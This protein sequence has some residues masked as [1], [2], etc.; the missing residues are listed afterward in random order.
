MGSGISTEEVIEKAT[1]I[2]KDLRIRIS[3][4]EAAMALL[5]KNNMN[6]RITQEKNNQRLDQL[7][8]HVFNL[9]LL[10]E[11]RSTY[12]SKGF[13]TRSEYHK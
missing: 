11:G 3:R 9:R 12:Y 2:I 10:E 7:D 6:I 1:M 13:H 4:V 8:E 5:E